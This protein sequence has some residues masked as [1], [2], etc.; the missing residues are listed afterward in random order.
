[1]VT[2]ENDMND[3]TKSLEIFLP[4]RSLNLQWGGILTVNAE[5]DAIAPQ[6]IKG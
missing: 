4:S 2:A 5:G 6:Q 1:V 3:R